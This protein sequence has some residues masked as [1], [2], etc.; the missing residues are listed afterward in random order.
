MI[1]AD[2]NDAGKEYQGLWETTRR[3]S[4]LNPLLELSEEARPTNILTLDF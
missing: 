3:G 4:F 1:G 2:W